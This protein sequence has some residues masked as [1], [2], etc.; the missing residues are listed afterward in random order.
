MKKVTLIFCVL[1][2][3]NH[4]QVDAQQ[5]RYNQFAIEASGGLAIPLSPKN[6]TPSSDY[7]GLNTF[8]ISGRYNFYSRFNREL[9]HLSV[10]LSYSHHGFKNSKDSDLGIA[11]NKLT[12]EAV[13][14]IGQQLGLGIRFYESYGLLAHAGAGVSFATPVGADFNEKVGHLQLGITP[15]IK[16]SDQFVFFADV[17]Y[18]A[19]LKQHYHY[20]GSLI[21][22][23]FDHKTGAFTT[24]SFGIMFYPGSKRHHADWY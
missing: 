5:A 13:Y 6:E 8:Q 9:Q 18:V 22:S 15:Q 19:N 10:R 12:A 1:F 24:I 21:Y 3:L 17:T 11:Y 20:D 14:N 7:I 2:A 23:N 4:S 16:I